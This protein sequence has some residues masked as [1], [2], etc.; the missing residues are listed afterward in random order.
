MSGKSINGNSHPPPK[1]NGRNG[2]T[3]SISNGKT[4]PVRYRTGQ[5]ILRSGIY[6]VVHSEHR[7]P[8]DVTLVEGEVFPRCAS[9][10]TKVQFQLLRAASGVGAGGFRVVLYELPDIEAA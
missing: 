10:G 3:Q 6:R 1:R 9:C 5:K 7:L 4:Q 2:K 8:H